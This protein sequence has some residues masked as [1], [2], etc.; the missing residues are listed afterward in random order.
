MAARPTRRRSTGTIA[1]PG[2]N[3][4]WAEPPGKSRHRTP[5]DRVAVVYYLCHNRHLEHPHFIEVPLA[6]PEE[7]LYLRGQSLHHIPLLINKGSTSYVR[8]S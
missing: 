4:V 8:T 2:R 5:A 3:K 1:S 6:S 7:G